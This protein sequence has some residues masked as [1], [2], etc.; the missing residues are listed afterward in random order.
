MLQQSQPPNIAEDH[1]DEPQAT[2]LIQQ[3]CTEPGASRLNRCVLWPAG[4]VSQSQDAA[5]LPVRPN[6]LLAHRIN[7]PVIQ[8][9]DNP[10]TD[11]LEPVEPLEVQRHGRA[12]S[13]RDYQ[14]TF[15]VAM[16]PVVRHS[17]STRGT[18]YIQC[19]MSAWD[20]RS[21]TFRGRSS[22]CPRTAALHAV[23]GPTQRRVTCCATPHLYNGRHTLGLRPEPRWE[24]HT[25]PLRQRDR[26]VSNDSALSRSVIGFLRRVRVA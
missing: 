3:V 24:P 5:R 25:Q 11:R 10:F 4:C 16:K 20:T 14:P 1:D 6:R 19:A 26:V 15:R 18:S 8:G 9:N 13:R 2:E 22:N 23:H 7:V 12:D 21:R 17:A